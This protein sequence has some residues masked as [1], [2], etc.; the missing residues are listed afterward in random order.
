MAKPF[1]SV[2]LDE[3]KCKGCITCISRCPTGAIRVRNGKAKILSELCIDCGQC[4]RLCPHRAK[5]AVFDPFEVTNNFKYKIAL[6]APSLYGQINN[7]NDIDYVLTALK[8]MGFDDIFEVSKAAELISQA[9]R[10]LMSE[11]KL[12]KPIISSACPAVVRL[13]RVRFPELCDNVLPLLSPMETAARMAK[14]EAEKSTGLDRSDIGVFFISP[15]PAKVTDTKNPIG[16]DKSEVDGV[17]AISDIYPKLIGYMN[18]IDEPEQLA[19]SGIIGVSWAGSGGEASALLNEK[20]LAADGIDE[21][22]KVLEEIEDDKLSDLDFIELN[23]CN[24]GCVGGVLT[25]ENPY[26]ARTRLQRLRKYLPVSKN[27]LQTDDIHSLD[28]S[29]DLEP[30][31]VMKLSDDLETALQMMNEIDKIYNRL[32]MLDCGSCGAPSCRALAEDIV[33]GYANENDCV[34]QLR[35]HIQSLARS[36][37]NLEGFI[38]APF[39]ETKNQE[40]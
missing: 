32:P 3:S 29:D 16:F 31:Q 1:H 13:I 28:W 40:K 30:A 24:G 5:K 26:V 9:T 21:V 6:P 7:L 37:S 10:K 36:I 38:P 12:K 8:M 2:T 34:F 22:I 14:D 15:C 20:Y 17:L 19:S 23:A 27:H 39:R 11:N 25:V 4:I 33:L 35:E 18:K